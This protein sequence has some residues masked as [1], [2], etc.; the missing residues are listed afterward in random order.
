MQYQSLLAANLVV[1][2]EVSMLTAKTF[3]LAMRRLQNVCGNDFLSKKLQV[4]VHRAF[5]AVLAGVWMIL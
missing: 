5:P 1:I 3:A 2:D 4:F